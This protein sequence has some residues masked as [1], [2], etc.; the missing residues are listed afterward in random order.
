MAKYVITRP[1]NNRKDLTG[2]RFGTLVALKYYASEITQYINGK[3]KLKVII[4]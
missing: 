3:R 2:K 1:A 4:P